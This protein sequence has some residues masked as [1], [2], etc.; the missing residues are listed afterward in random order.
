MRPM[1]TDV[2]S[3]AEV[4]ARLRVSPR[5]VYRMIESGELPAMN[6]A[7]GDTRPTYRIRC[8]DLD[9]YVSGRTGSTQG[10]TA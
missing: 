1:A 2:L 3:V 7:V 8:A 9:A 10:T 4:A 5:H 6:I